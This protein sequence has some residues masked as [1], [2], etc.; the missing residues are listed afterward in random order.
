MARYKPPA[1]QEDVTC[2][3]IPMIDVMFL[4][5]LFF[6]LGADMGQ[7]DLEEVVLPLADMVKEDSNQR[8]TEERTTVNVHHKLESKGFA[9]AVYKAGNICRDES[10]WLIAIRGKEFTRDTINLQLQV[11]ADLDREAE[12]DKA[13]GRRLSKRKVMVRADQGAPYGYVQKVI[14]ACALALIYKIEV[15]AAKPPKA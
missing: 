9:C 7:R 1:V 8:E 10:H 5:L 12:P 14:E 4:L 15:G 2:N 11:E 3:L 6:M 13:S